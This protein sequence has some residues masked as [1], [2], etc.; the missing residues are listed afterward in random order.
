[1]NTNNICFL[2]RNIFILIL[3]LSCWVHK[4]Y[5]EILASFAWQRALHLNARN[6]AKHFIHF[7]FIFNKNRKKKGRTI[8]YLLIIACSIV[9]FVY[10]LWLL[11]WMI[12]DLRKKQYNNK[13]MTSILNLVFPSCSHIS[14]LVSCFVNEI[15]RHW[16]N[17]SFAEHDMPCKS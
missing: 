7:F 9:N 4:F 3:L 8:C 6:M 13:T 12:K 17:P 5:G 11:K 14:S 15:I 10:F 2:C 16:L 1:M